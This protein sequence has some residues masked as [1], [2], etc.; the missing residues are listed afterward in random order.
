M[1]GDGIALYVQHD[2]FGNRTFYLKS[3]EDVKIIA[4]GYSR[5]AIPTSGIASIKLTKKM[6]E[7]NGLVVQCDIDLLEFLKD[8]SSSPK[9]CVVSYTNIDGYTITGLASIEGDLNY[10]TLEGFVEIEKVVFVDKYKML[11]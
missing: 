8:V 7:I 5:E 9:N 1:A 10:S 11:E 3:Q 6:G 4:G 2:D